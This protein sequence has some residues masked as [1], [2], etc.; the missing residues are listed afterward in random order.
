[1]TVLELIV[2]ILKQHNPNDEVINYHYE[3]CIGEHL[4][5]CT[6]MP[7]PTDRQELK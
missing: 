4:Y 1:M 5:R 3:V 2:E 6:R 7:C